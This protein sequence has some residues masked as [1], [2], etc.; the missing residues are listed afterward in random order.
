[1]QRPGSREGHGPSQ[2]CQLMA[3]P[4]MCFVGLVQVCFVLL[5][6]LIVA[7]M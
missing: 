4:L 5:E 1:M 2:V 7:N 3:G 6:L